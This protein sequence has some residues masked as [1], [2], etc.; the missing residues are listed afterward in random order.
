VALNLKTLLK[1]PFLVAKRLKTLVS[2]AS[3]HELFT[4]LLWA[5]ELDKIKDNE[6]FFKRP[7]KIWTLWRGR[8]GILKNYD[9][10]ESFM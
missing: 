4:T 1:Y 3:S 5:K 10:L 7:E 2:F 8:R 6:K 9:H